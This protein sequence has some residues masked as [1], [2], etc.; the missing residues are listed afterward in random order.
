MY[1]DTSRGT[2]TYIDK[3][4]TEPRKAPVIPADMKAFN[5]KLI[6]RKSDSAL[7]RIDGGTDK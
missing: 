5:A 2:T 4:M 3:D 1:S 6:A 7:A